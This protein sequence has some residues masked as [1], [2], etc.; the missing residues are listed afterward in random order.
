MAEVFGQN[1]MMTGCGA[2][3]VAEGEVGDRGTLQMDEIPHLQ[4]SS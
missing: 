3:D 4:S 2:F 1:L